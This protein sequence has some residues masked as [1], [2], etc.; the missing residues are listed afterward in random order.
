MKKSFLWLLLLLFQIGF[1]Q[2]N[3]N[4]KGYF[5]YN[6]IK[7]VSESSTKL[8][9]AAE[10]AL[11]TKNLATNELKTINTID[12]LSGQTISAMYHSETFN[13]TVLGYQNG[14]MIVINDADG[15][16]LN[17]V[18][19]INKNIPANIK[20]INHFMEYDGIL[21]VSCDFGIVQYKLATL[22]F[23]DTYFIGPSGQETRVYQTTVFNNEIYAVTQY[24]G[25]RK[26]SVTNPNLIDYAQWQVFNAGYWTGLVT[27]NNQLIAMST[28]NNVYKFTGTT[29]QQIGSLGQPALD[30]RAY[31]N[32]LIA[33]CSNKVIIFNTGLSP[34]VTI[35][36]SQVTTHPVTF[37]CGTVIGSNIYIGTNEN[38]ILTSTISNPIAFD[39]IMP[40]GPQMN[41][42]FSI[43]SSASNLWAVYGGY[44]ITYNPYTYL[45]FSL[46]QFGISKYNETNGWLNIPYSEVLGAKS[47][48]RIAIDPNDEKNV[49][50]GSYHNGL[51]SVIDDHP[52]TLYDNTN[53]TLEIS[54]GSEIW[55]N[56]TTFDKNGNLWM[57]DSRTEKAL[58]VLKPGGTW[59]SYDLHT[60][61]DNYANNDFCKIA[62][63]NSGTKWIATYK[64]GVVAFNEN[65][66]VGLKKITQGEDAGNLPSIDVR[67]IAV[68]NRNQ[69]W[70]GTNRGLR[71]LSSTG[72]YNS[73][74]QM[75]ANAIIFDEN[76]L[77]RELLQDQYISDI[78]V[79]GSNQKW[80]STVD[81]GVFLFSP[82]GQE[83]IYHFT[84]DN[85]PLPS[86]VI[87]DIEINAITGEVFFATD[88]GLVS[89]KGT[90]TRPADNL[91][92]VYVYPNPV[93][94]N[95]DG[96]VKVAGLVSKANVKITDIEGNLVYETTSEGGTIEW[97]TTAFGKYK[98]ASGVYMIFIA[99]EDTAETAVKKVMIVR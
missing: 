15:T 37:T 18:D 13:K 14:L 36:N 68:D 4:W 56:S 78:A 84:I 98:V 91:D 17:V 35:Q 19:I 22:E 16:M 53:S 66:S 9:A 25:I 85:S 57:T 23:G 21:Y 60:I 83:T 10:N 11:F 61:L 32:Y 34:V 63:D 65:S 51:L 47:L 62:I 33:T 76:G 72:A 29:Y 80:I 81:S 46:T 92:A 94:P 24:Y 79:N 43:S 41:N 50:I 77:A 97:D 71:V 89:F 1:S 67:A 12:G 5:S 49:Y 31:G 55:V 82:N 64:N 74:E 70:I 42:M 87:N 3:Q 95:F 52:T 88:K 44:D 8:F 20:K 2:Q 86:N 59:Q 40:S 69:V 75:K 90:S 30:F 39:F 99:A 27:F 93:R 26:A 58:N 54:V 38:G 28:D 73:P 48:V 96:T 7:D 6:Q 45:G